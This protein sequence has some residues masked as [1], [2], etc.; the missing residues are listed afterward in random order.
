MKFYL[1]EDEKNY[2]AIIATLK[3][4]FPV[5][6]LDNLVGANFFGS[7]VLL[8]KEEQVGTVGNILSRRD[9][10]VL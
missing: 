5:A 1:N 10:V 6:G 3:S 8:G 4:T 2:S 9:S 7:T